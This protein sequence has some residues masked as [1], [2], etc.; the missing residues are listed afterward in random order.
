LYLPE[1]IP[2][3]DMTALRE[4]ESYD[5][6]AANVLRPFLAGD[7]LED[8]VAALCQTA[9]D[10]PVPIVDLGPGTALLELFHGPTAAFKDFG[11][12]FL[13]TCFDVMDVGEIAILV[14]TSGDTGAAVAGACHGRRR[15]EV[16]VLFPRDGVSPRQAHQL[17][18]WGG[19]VS[20]FAVLGTFDD[21]QRMVK[22]VFQAGEWPSSARLTSANSINVGRLLPQAVYYGF[23]ASRYEAAHGRAPGFVIPSGNVGNAVGAF[24]AREIGFPIRRIVLATNANRVVPDWFETGL[25]SP[26]PSV[27]TLANAMDVG[28]P[29]NM[30]RLFALFPDRGSICRCASSVSVDDDQI[31]STIARGPRRWGQVFCP[32]TA[33]AVRAREGMDTDDWIVVATAHPAKFDHIVEPLIGGPVEVPPGLSALLERPRRYVEIAPTGEALLAAWS[34]A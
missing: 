28:N 20:S 21:C 31:R 34:R 33:T 13:A 27:A 16:G 32:H 30:E 3:L 26:R 4:I 12:R 17:T 18:C 5:L 15:L 19:N 25:W 9:F 10:F 8:D 11:A 24:L 29:S 7:P 14:A 2:H 23:A 1:R 22:E 6:F